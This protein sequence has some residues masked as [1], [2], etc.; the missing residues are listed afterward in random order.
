RPRRP[1]GSLRAALTAAVRLVR[2][3]LFAGRRPVPVVWSHMK[4]RLAV[5]DMAGTT[6]RDDDA[7][8]ICLRGALESAAAV[9]RDD[10]NRVMGIRK[11]WATRTLLLEPLA[12]SAVTEERVMAIHDDFLRRMIEHYRTSPTVEPMPDTLETFS[13]LQR[14][15]VRIA[16]DTG[17]SRDIVDVIL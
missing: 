14:D 2:G 13:A 16:L 8:N 12:P 9:T 4:I 10:V 3:K 17:F 11:P 15:G 1:R 7:V 6:V 5:F